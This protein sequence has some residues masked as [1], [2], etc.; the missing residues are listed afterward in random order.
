VPRDRR[1][2]VID[3]GLEKGVRSDR[4]V[5]LDRVR[6]KKFWSPFSDRRHFVGRAKE[7]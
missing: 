5:H 4:I 6:V 1:G 3:R 7:R 2:V